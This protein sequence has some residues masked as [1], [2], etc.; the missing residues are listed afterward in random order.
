MDDNSNV[1]DLEEVRRK[2]RLTPQECRELKKRLER[3][4][5]SIAR[6]DQLI[7]ELKEGEK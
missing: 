2:Q 3:I 6:I 7:K 5:V 4:K 1:V